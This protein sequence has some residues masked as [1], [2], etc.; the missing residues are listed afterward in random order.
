MRG[1][2]LRYKVSPVHAGIDLPI[3]TFGMGYA[4]FPR[5][6]GDRPYSLLLELRWNM[7]PPYTRG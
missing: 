6:R 4:C 1:D 2:V 5:T 7:F 3:S